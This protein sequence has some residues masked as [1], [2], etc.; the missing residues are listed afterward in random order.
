M[1]AGSRPAL[2]AAALWARGGLARAALCCLTLLAL[3]RALGAQAPAVTLTAR[4]VPESGAAPGATVSAVFLVRNG[5]RATVRV[6]PRVTLPAGWSLATGGAPFA[7]AAGESDPWVVGITVSPSAAAGAYV[8]P[9]AARL[10]DGTGLR[11]SVRLVVAARRAVAVALA[12]APDFA[13]GGEEYEV[14]FRVVNRGNVAAA[15][16]L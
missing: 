7:L 9:V 14:R 12:R 16:R 8:V 5:G 15:V 4:A 2:V 3:A 1:H 6:T 10:D 11:D 13:V